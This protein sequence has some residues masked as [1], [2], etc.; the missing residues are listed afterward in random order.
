M[1]YKFN[2]KSIELTDIRLHGDEKYN[3]N[4]HGNKPDDYEYIIDQSYT[5]KWIDL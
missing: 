5:N 2:I 1:E 3:S 4:N